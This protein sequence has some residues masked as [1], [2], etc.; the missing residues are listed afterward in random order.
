MNI[1]S[2]KT[3]R[4]YGYDMSYL[5]R[6]AGVTVVLVHGTI[7]DYRYRR[8]QTRA[9]G[10][11]YR[12]IAVSLRHFY[13]EQWNGEGDDFSL[14][15]YAADLASFI[16]GLNAGPVHVLGHS[17]GGDVVLVLA[18]EHQ[19]LL[20]SVILAEPAPIFNLLP[21]TPEAAEVTEKSRVFYKA[22]LQCL[23]KGDSE[24][25]IGKFLERVSGRRWEKRPERQRRIF[26]DNAWSLKSLLSD[27]EV[28]LTC[29]DVGKVGVPVLFVQ[30]E[31][32]PRA[33][34]FM[35]DGLQSCLKQHE[36][37]IIPKAAHAMN[38]ANPQAFNAAVLDFMER[39]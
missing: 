20:R 17:R 37:V 11:R 9:F 10:E 22:A 27:A 35:M 4:V 24:G 7:N 6:G 38:Q 1:R 18:L 32:S 13:P 26:L 16:K 8:V 25:A 34:K 19:E 33:Y 31:E 5:E 2:L 36:E 15:Q 39:H 14:R 30:G 28:P 29:A 23:E 3:M 21:K 12:A